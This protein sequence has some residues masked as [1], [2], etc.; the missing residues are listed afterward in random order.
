MS[1][2]REQKKDSQLYEELTGCFIGT[3]LQETFLLG[4]WFIGHGTVPPNY[5]FFLSCTSYTALSCSTSA[6]G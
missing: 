1:S 6:R 3:V 4:F 2:S 5:I